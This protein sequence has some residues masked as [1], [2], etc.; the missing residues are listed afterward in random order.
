MST[1]HIDDVRIENYVAQF[2]GLTPDE[3]RV[4]YLTQTVK[5]KII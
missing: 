4:V 2:D 3:Q 5:D 1:L